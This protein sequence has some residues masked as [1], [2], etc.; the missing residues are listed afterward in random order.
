VWRTKQMQSQL[1]TMKINESGTPLYQSI[2]L[3]VL[4]TGLCA[5]ACFY[6]AQSNFLQIRVSL[7]PGGT[8]GNQISCHRVSDMTA[9]RIMLTTSLSPNVLAISS[10]TISIAADGRPYALR[11][12]IG[13]GV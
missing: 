12:S 10:L 5:R 8:C 1:E 3:I 13:V 7:F 11:S 2:L 9:P 4:R 6:L